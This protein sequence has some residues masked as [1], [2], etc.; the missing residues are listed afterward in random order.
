LKKLFTNILL[1]FLLSIIVAGCSRKKDKFLNKN[2]HSLTTKYNFLFNGNNLYTE[3]LTDLENDVKENFWGLLPIEKFKYY[4]IDDKER[5]TNFT[6]SEE[7]ATLAI[8][9]HSMN[10]DGKERNPIM[11]QAYFLLGKSRYFDNRFIPAMEAFNYILFKYPS[12]KYINLVKIWKEKINI[13]LD[14]NK[15]AIDNLKEI[16]EENNLLIEERSLANSYLAQAFINIDQID[17]AA[18]YLNRSN[19]QYNNLK[20]NPRKT[21]LLAQLFQEMSIKDTAHDLYSEIIKLHR[22]TP[23]KFY[24]QSFIKRST[25]SDS[26][27][28]SILELKELT[29][30]FENNDFTDII[31]HQI[32]MLNLKKNDFDLILTDSLKILNDSLAALN[33]NKSLRSNPNDQRLIAKNYN[34]LAE[35]NFR[36]KEYL[37]AGLYY[38]STLSELDGKSRQFRKIKRKRDNLNDLIFYESIAKELDSIINLINMSDEKRR[39]FF[40]VYVDQLKARVSKAKKNNDNFGSSNTIT[41]TMD[42]ESA[43]FYFYN[44]T[45]VAYGKNDFKNRWGNRR[46]EDNWRWSNS[47]V[48][49]DNNNTEGQENILN[50][51]SIF[52]A[53]YYI[54]L[55]PNDPIMI[56]SIN[57]RRNDAYFRLGAIYKDQFDEYQ[58]SNEKLFGLLSNDP[59]EN[60]LPPSKYFI[61]KNFIS[62]DSLIKA[63]EFKEDIIVNHR[64]SKYADILL[65][66]SSIS[67][68]KQNSNEIYEQLY[69]DFTNQKY[70]QVISECDKYILDFSTEAIV[71]KFEFLKALAIARVF[72]FKEYKKALTFIKLNYSSAVEGK[73]AELILDE[74]LPLVENNKFISNDVSENFKII[75]QFEIALDNKISTQIKE[76]SEYINNIDYLD[77]TV[78]K[79]FY[80]NIVTFVVVHGLKSYDG[81]LGLAER[82]EKTIDIQ[83]DSFFVVSSDNYKTIQIHKNLDKYEIK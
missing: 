44:T 34:E 65:D 32:A 12:S 67:Y 77:L 48:N 33:F 72:G 50:K 75:Y 1:F 3:G 41:S 10:V 55:I 83:A 6:R 22:K 27:D 26:I 43:L 15:Y 17:S 5:E 42:S 69:L 73:E 62:L 79:D 31:Y 21:F 11:D 2:F 64:D 19:I 58:I 81:S 54:S 49:I 25:I 53:D 38:D 70:I 37:Q 71:A 24:I 29:E 61:Y 16:L 36:N 57:N 52:S 68:E 56:D 39:V 76:L 80:N 47:N 20:N 14:Q 28:N 60:L 18:Y 78:S 35:L 82:L 13:R 7:K 74:V 8:Q 30:N 23:R 59:Y 4:E 45:A 63:E 9:K 51:D 66:P 40:G 46:L